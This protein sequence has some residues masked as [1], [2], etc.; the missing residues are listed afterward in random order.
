MDTASRDGDSNQRRKGKGK[1]K[2]KQRAVPVT[3][4]TV[5]V[6]TLAAAEA[7]DGDVQHNT[8]PRQHKFSL[9]KR[10]K[11]RRAQEIRI[12]VDDGTALGGQPVLQRRTT[13][14]EERKRQVAEYETIWSEIT[15]DLPPQLSKKQ[16]TMISIGGVIGTG[17]FLGIAQS[18]YTGGPL[19]LLLGY[20]IVGTVVYSVV[21]SVAE[22]V[23]WLPGVGGIVRLAGLYVDDAFGFAM[24]WNAWF[25]WAVVLPAEITAAT[26]LMNDYIGSEHTWIF[27]LGILLVAVG[28][29]CFGAR[30]YGRVEFW[31]AAGKILTIVVL[32]IISIYLDA[33]HTPQTGRIGF[34]NWRHPGPFAQFKDVQGNF[35]RFLGFW[36]VL[37]Q[38]SYSF[39]GAEVPDVAGGEVIRAS[40]NIPHA[41]RRIWLRILL[42][43]VLSVFA[44]GLLVPHTACELLPS[45]E[46]C[47]HYLLDDKGDPV[48]LSTSIQSPFVIA[49]RKIGWSAGA[50]LVNFA[51]LASAWSAATSDIYI[52]SRY[53]FFLARCN[54]AWSFCG[55]LYQLKKTAETT[56]TSNQAFGDDGNTTDSD[57]EM[58]PIVPTSP[59]ATDSDTGPTRLSDLESGP[60]GTDDSLDEAN[61]LTS[62]R[63]HAF[64]SS[65]LTVPPWSR[66]DHPP[67]Q[68]SSH[69]PAPPGLAAPP[70]TH[71]DEPATNPETPNATRA[72]G[73]AG[74]A[75]D[76][77]P[78]P[79][80]WRSRPPPQFPTSKTVP[81]VGV[82]LAGAVGCL[83]FIG[84][85]TTKDGSAT[86]AAKGFGYLSATSSVTAL[87]SWIG[88]LITYLRWFYGSRYALNQDHFKNTPDAEFI[89]AN[90]PHWQPWVAIYGLAMCCIILFFNGWCVAALAYHLSRFI[91]PH[92]SLGACFTITTSNGS[93]RPASANSNLV[94]SREVRLQSPSLSPRIFLFRYTSSY[95]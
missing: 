35:G 86:A 29:N 55:R 68:V 27:T 65:Y 41:V 14:P 94:L 69:S 59:S 95:T 17:V 79:N 58:T 62:A 49:M 11:F 45:A 83:A 4:V 31:F 84:A 10:I 66:L 28:I 90:R 36:T 32:L 37:I 77:D 52:S 33:V 6:V 19:G 18:L 7:Y 60:E 61:P 70:P 82:L 75:P 85:Q 73:S 78:T 67:R 81:W 43:Y 5:P 25:N 44:A 80:T 47:E 21:I 24:G 38:A 93:L 89:R 22:I 8:G 42:F 51:F 16:I 2:G 57:V 50:Q 26:V 13:T 48:Q 87:L 88:M 40:K 63:P 64:T 20:S 91:V 12:L 92:R 9:R 15:L 46:G 3:P 76:G 23:A 30:L 1:D 34:R 71:S 56:S 39:F 74:M 53:M 72:D 54:H